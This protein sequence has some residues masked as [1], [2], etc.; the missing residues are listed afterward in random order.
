MEQ[1]EVQ[2][3]NICTIR[4]Y[5]LPNCQLALP[6]LLS[7]YVTKITSSFLSVPDFFT[8]LFMIFIFHLTFNRNAMLILFSHEESLKKLKNFGGNTSYV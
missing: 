4:R 7:S 3:H 8:A 6:G 2:I 5:V 1:L